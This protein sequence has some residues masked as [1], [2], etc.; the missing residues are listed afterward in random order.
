MPLPTGIGEVNSIALNPLVCL[1]KDESIPRDLQDLIRK[2]PSESLLTRVIYP[3]EVPNFVAIARTFSVS[4]EKVMSNDVSS[5]IGPEVENSTK[6][7][8]IDINLG[9]IFLT[10]RL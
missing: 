10:F 6:H 9:K 2:S 8:P 5:A 1:A 7:S 4:P 3:H